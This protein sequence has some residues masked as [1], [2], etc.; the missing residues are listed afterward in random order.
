VA[1]HSEGHYG[2]TV[3]DPMDRKYIE[4]NVCDECLRTR[5]ERVLQGR[6][7][8]LVLCQGAFVGITPAR[9]PLMPWRPGADDDDGVRPLQIEPEDIH[10]VDKN[11]DPL[12]PEIRWAP[13]ALEFKRTHI[14]EKP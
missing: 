2:S 3:W 5:S 4:I 6:E 11:G 7:Y 10:A 9:R 8:K 1:F 13:S 12:F 14:K